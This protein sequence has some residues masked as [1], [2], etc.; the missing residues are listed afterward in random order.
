M[1]QAGDILQVALFFGAI[2]SI[3]VIIE[4][5]FVFYTR[6][7]MRFTGLLL[8][9]IIADNIVTWCATLISMWSMSLVSGIIEPQPYGGILWH[10]F[11]W[12]V[13]TPFFTMPFW[14]IGGRFLVAL[15]GTVLDISPYDSVKGFA[16]RFFDDK[17]AYLLFRSTM[18]AFI[19]NTF[20]LYA[21]NI[22][23]FDSRCYLIAFTS[24]FSFSAFCWDTFLTSKALSIQVE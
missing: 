8:G 21:K 6:S 17:A 23:E 13:L 9:R 18:F 22:W 10:L 11:Y 16:S 4:L 19:L 7:I 24:F 14:A 20:V 12:L 1:D 5:V 2:W 3:P 15:Y